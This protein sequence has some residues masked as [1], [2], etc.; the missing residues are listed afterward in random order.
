[1]PEL[2]KNF[3]AGA[4]GAEYSRVNWAPRIYL[5]DLRRAKTLAKGFDIVH[6]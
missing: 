6:I 4:V 3:F 2:A 1:M 5:E